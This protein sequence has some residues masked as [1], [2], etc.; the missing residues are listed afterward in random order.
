MMITRVYKG[1]AVTGRLV[2]AT[3]KRQV[4]NV[5]L[6]T[7]PITVTIKGVS[8]WEQVMSII[9]KHIDKAR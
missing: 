9:I 5:Q 3:D 2:A 1:V 7:T 8:S 4:W 6:S